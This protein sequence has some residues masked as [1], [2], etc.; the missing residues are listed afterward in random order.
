MAVTT[1]IAALVAQHWDRVLLDNLYPSLQFYQFA[2]KKRLPAGAGKTAWWS[3]YVKYGA[4]GGI[5]DGTPIGT[6]DLCAKRISA[7]VA[8]YGIA[9]AHSD[10]IIMTGISDVVQD[11]VQEVSKS[12]ALAID[13]KIRGTISG[14]G[15]FLAASGKA[16]GTVLTG[17]PLQY[18]DI[19][20]GVLALDGN[21]AKRFPDGNYVAIAHPG[22]LAQL[23][24]STTANASWI[25]VNKYANSQ[26]VGKIYRGE[27]GMLHGVRFIQST[28]NKIYSGAAALS[29]T[30]GLSGGAT[31]ANLYMFGAGAFGCV[32][33]DGGNAKTY[34]KQLGS[35]GTADPINQNATVGAKI[36]FGAVDL[37]CTNRLYRIAH[38]T[39]V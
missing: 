20:K 10:F 16:A 23:K 32:E 24:S 28:Q 38:G 21:N 26:T 7:V 25:D 33:L 9:A 35:A 2:D 15:T 34:I 1:T 17:T 19:I 12:L 30:H 18:S 22:G 6:S 3:R 11:S 29:G 14:A 31:G 8:G 4:A 27:V 36:Y 39:T 13:N 5:T 37:D